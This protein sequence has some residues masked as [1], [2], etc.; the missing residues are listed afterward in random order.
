MLPLFGFCPERL[1]HLVRLVFNLFRF[2]ELSR[3]WLGHFLWFRRLF[4]LGEIQREI[5]KLLLTNFV[6]IFTNLAIFREM[7]PIIKMILMAF[8]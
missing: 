8:R 1:Q 5:N 4:V 3:Y 7:I 6:R 2:L